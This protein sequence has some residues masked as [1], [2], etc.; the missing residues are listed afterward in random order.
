MGKRRLQEE[1]DDRRRRR[2]GDTDGCKNDYDGWKP[3]AGSFAPHPVARVAMS[4]VT[5]R[6]FFDRYV[7]R[8]RP[9]VLTGGL[10]G[11][12]WETAWKGWTDDALATCAARDDTVRVETRSSVTGAYGVGRYETMRFGDFVQ[13]FRRGDET[14]YL[15]A[16][17]AAIDAQGRPQV[18]APPASRLLGNANGGPPFRPPLAGKLVPANVNVWM[19]ASADGAS[20]GLHHDHHDNL[21][22][23]LRGTKRFELY[24]PSEIGSM[25]TVGTPVAVHRNGRVNYE[26]SGRTRADGDDGS[27]AARVAAGAVNV[28]YAELEAAE[29]AMA[30]E[31]EGGAARVEAAERAVDAAM[32]D[33][34]FTAAGGRGAEG[35]GDDGDD[36]DG[37]GFFGGHDD[38]DDVDDSDLDADVDS[39]LDEEENENGGEGA[40]GEGAGRGA[41]GGA[42]AD[43]PSFSRVDRDG[44]SEF[45][46][47]ARAHAS[48]RV[49]TE[50]RAGEVLYLPAGWFHEVTSTGDGE[51]NRHMALNYWF[52]PPAPGGEDASTYAFETPYGSRARQAMWEDDWA[53]WEELHQSSAAK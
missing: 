39:D 45:P 12:C 13:R 19:G 49:Q 25:Y 22:V 1:A 35:D 50:V 29:S 11:T 53:M 17:P 2:L 3:P 15:T 46:R 24:A 37:D 21:Y 33:A 20:S 8:R 16:S 51:T 40:G 30:N 28:A 14:C 5:P 36:L 42:E 9:V 48:A 18:G 34:A 10:E 7:A 31:E 38:F 47:F 52:H 43:P 32:D 27:V 4:T 26:E 44:L 41:G 23:L 6:D